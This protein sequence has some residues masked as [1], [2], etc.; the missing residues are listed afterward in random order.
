[1]RIS[2]AL[3]L[4]CVLACGGA[5]TDRG[6]RV[7]SCA[8]YAVAM[9]APLARL[10]RAAD[11][12]SLGGTPEEGARGARALAGRLAAERDGLAAMAIDE[13]ELRGVHRPLVDAL[14]E[15]TGA[16]ELLGDVLERREEA[17][18]EEARAR[19]LHANQRWGAAV[20]AVR[21]VCPID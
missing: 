17:R 16:L 1:M 21:A 4:V 14:A 7:R 2:A 13:R 6:P 11:E 10:A 9:R 19:L 20:D 5:Q 12:A 15:M 18:R 3:A 8:D